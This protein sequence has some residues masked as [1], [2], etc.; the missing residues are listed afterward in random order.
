MLLELR[1][2]FDLATDYLQTD[3]ST[4][5]LLLTK[6]PQQGH[7]LISQKDQLLLYYILYHLS[8]PSPLNNFLRSNQSNAKESLE[9]C[10]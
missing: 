7:S 4:V 2:M 5:L 8:S 1:E 9:K 10:V 6:L 3:I